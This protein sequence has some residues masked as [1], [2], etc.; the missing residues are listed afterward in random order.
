MKE[1]QSFRTAGKTFVPMMMM[2]QGTRE[3]GT[4]LDLWRS[5]VSVPTLKEGFDDFPGYLFDSSD[6][7]AT[8]RQR[9]RKHVLYFLKTQHKLKERFS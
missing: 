6:A 9:I 8:F 4:Q 5:R 7:C 2:T 3:L 1:G